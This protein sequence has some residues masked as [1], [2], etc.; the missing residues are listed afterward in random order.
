VEIG[1]SSIN[2]A[3]QSRFA[4]RTETDSNLRSAVFFNKFRTVA[5]VQ[6]VCRCNTVI[7]SCIL[8]TQTKLLGITFVFKRNRLIIDKNSAVIGY[9]RKWENNGTV[10][11][12]IIDI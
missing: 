11:S 5:N 6:E 3:E 12:Y 7:I 2:F 8:D 9:W 1:P 10:I 4:L